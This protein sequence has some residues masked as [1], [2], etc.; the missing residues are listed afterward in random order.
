MGLVLLFPLAV[1]A[2]GVAA[3]SSRARRHAE[4]TSRLSV[5][6]ASPIEDRLAG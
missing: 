3:R 1:T 4:V 6:D 5:L 2:I